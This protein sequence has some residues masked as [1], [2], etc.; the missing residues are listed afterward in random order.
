[1]LSFARTRDGTDIQVVSLANLETLMQALIAGG[2]CACNQERGNNQRRGAHLGIFPLKLGQS[3][4][5]SAACLPAGLCR[6][7][8]IQRCSQLRGF[9]S[10]PARR[11]FVDFSA[12]NR[13]SAR[14]HAT[15]L[16]TSIGQ[17]M[18]ALSRTCL[19][20]VDLPEADL[21]RHLTKRRGQTRFKKL[22][23]RVDVSTP[24]AL[25]CLLLNLFG[26][27]LGQQAFSAIM[28]RAR[29]IARR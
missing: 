21:A 16:P 1:V 15:A 22:E 26:V 23:Q 10:E 27:V 12:A 3:R 19:S 13:R 4:K 25:A 14:A 11:R 28:S 18:V 8:A 7:T 20:S 29:A 5:Q 17:A 6:Q 2:H 24:L 9:Y